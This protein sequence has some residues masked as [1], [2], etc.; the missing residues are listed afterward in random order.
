LSGKG[1]EQLHE[2]PKALEC[3]KKSLEFDPGFERASESLKRL[4]DKKRN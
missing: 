2:I 1:Y 4:A 3:Y